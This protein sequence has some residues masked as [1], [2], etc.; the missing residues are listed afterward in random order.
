MNLFSVIIDEPFFKYFFSFSLFVCVCMCAHSC[1][2]VCVRVSKEARG[3]CQPLGA[4]VTSSCEPPGL[5]LKTKFLSP[6][7][8]VNAL[9]C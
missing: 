4:G 5:V 8:T 2:H 6:T 9:R 1:A 3:G 7:R